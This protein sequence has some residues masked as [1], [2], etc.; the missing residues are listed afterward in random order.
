MTRIIY[1]SHCM[2]K[3]VHGLSTLDTLIPYVQELQ[4]WLLIMLLLANIDWNFSSGKT[5]ATHVTTILLNLD[6]IFFLSIKDITSIGIQ[7]ETQ[8]VTSFFFWNLNVGHLHL[9][10]PLHSQHRVWLYV[11]VVCFLPIFFFILFS[12]FS[13]SFFLFSS[14]LFLF[15]YVVTM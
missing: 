1:L 13:F 7:E 3:K 14:F 2:L 9:K 6:S 4:E 15:M 5:S 10:V 8:L 11:N 12:F